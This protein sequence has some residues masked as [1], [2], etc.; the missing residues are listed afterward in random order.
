[1]DGRC[2]KHAFDRGQLEFGSFYFSVGPA[3]ADLN[4]RTRHG[5]PPDMMVV[6]SKMETVSLCPVRIYSQKDKLRT[7]TAAEAESEVMFPACGCMKSTGGHKQE[8][9][10][11]MCA[12]ESRGF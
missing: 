7:L 8:R 5:V 10:F 1:M 12:K 4:W 11:Q 9:V 6:V 3:R 2:G